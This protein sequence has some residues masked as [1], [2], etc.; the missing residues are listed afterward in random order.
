MDAQADAAAKER[1]R[2]LGIVE[3]TTRQIEDMRKP[4]NSSTGVPPMVSWLLLVVAVGL[5]AWLATGLWPK[6]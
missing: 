4:G 3:S 2:L 5:L 1:D 6:G